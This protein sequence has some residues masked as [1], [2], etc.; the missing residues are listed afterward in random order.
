MRLSVEEVSKKRGTSACTNAS[1]A[2]MVK[3]KDNVKLCK[4]CL[5]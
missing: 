1:N 3:L 5:R 2:A 4:Q